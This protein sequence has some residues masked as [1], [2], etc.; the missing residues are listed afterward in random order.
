MESKHCIES[1]RSAVSSNPMLQDQLS[2]Q[3]IPPYH[4]SMQYHNATQNQC[5]VKPG[6]DA[7]MQRVCILGTGLTDS[8]VQPMQFPVLGPSTS[9]SVSVPSESTSTISTDSTISTQSQSVQSVLPHF[10]TIPMVMS[11]QMTNR[12]V[13]TNQKDRATPLQM[14][15]A[16]GLSQGLSQRRPGL[17]PVSLWPTPLTQS[18]AISTL[19]GSTLDDLGR[20]CRSPL[21][22]AALQPS[23]PLL[24]PTEQLQCPRPSPITRVSAQQDMAETKALLMPRGVAISQQMQLSPLNGNSNGRN[25]MSSKNGNDSNDISNGEGERVRIKR[26][27]AEWIPMRVDGERLVIPPQFP[28]DRNQDLTLDLD[29]AQQGPL[30]EMRVLAVLQQIVQNLIVILNGIA[31]AMGSSVIHSV[32]TQYRQKVAVSTERLAV[33]VGK[34]MRHRLDKLSMTQWHRVQEHLRKKYIAEIVEQIKKHPLLPT[35]SMSLS[36][37]YQCYR[38]IAMEI[39]QGMKQKAEQYR[40]IQSMQ[41]SPGLEPELDP[42]T[43]SKIKMET[44]SSGQHSVPLVSTADPHSV[45]DLKTICLD[46]CPLPNHYSEGSATRATICCGPGLSG[47]ALSCL[48][49]DNLTKCSNALYAQCFNL[50][51]HQNPSKQVAAANG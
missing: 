51:L 33:L 16:R 14:V 44:T 36:S 32:E 45:S 26:E 50:L 28:Q 6:T 41:W 42:W 31:L 23:A 8:M 17:C 24:T 29:Q 13:I 49:P 38:Q 19:S 25:G 48:A 2:M 3:R 11:N 9:V 39:L 47:P 1:Q 10:D 22:S 12:M 46:R 5:A 40:Q 37:H 18:A 7:P 20:R 4:H 21:L 15:T 30:E 27:E 43:T 34:F 35:Q